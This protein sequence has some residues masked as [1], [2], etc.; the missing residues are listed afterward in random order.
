MSLKDGKLKKFASSK[1]RRS[2]SQSEG[3]ANRSLQDSVM[4]GRGSVT[5]SN[6]VDMMGTSGEDGETEDC[7]ERV[8]LLCPGTSV[9][10]TATPLMSGEKTTRK[11]KSVSID[12]TPK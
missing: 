6:M 5:F 1:L 4:M 10:N 3:R 12:L 11:E 8:P 7:D 2:A 9:S